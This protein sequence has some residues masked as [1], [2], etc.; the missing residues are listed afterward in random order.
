MP[1][2]S[3]DFESAP[4]SDDVAPPEN[5]YS[6]SLHGNAGKLTKFEIDC[7]AGRTAPAYLMV[8]RRAKAAELPVE[9][10]GKEHEL[11]DLRASHY[12]WT[13]KRNDGKPMGLGEVQ[14]ALMMWGTQRARQIEPAYTVP[15][16]SLKRLL[17]TDDAL[18]NPFIDILSD[19]EPGQRELVIQD[20][21]LAASLV[22]LGLITPSAEPCL[23]ALMDIEVQ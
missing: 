13:V 19:A 22:G 23:Y 16:S 9:I 12:T 17:S 7:V 1:T 10:P 8:R 6:I 20:L 11:T 15:L 18:I 4:D 3:F 5:G 14:F 21:E 2:L